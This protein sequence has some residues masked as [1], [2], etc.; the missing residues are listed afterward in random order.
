MFTNRPNNSRNQTFQE[1]AFAIGSSLSARW[2]RGH[3]GWRCLPPKK[4]PGSRRVWRS[5]TGRTSGT[6]SRSSSRHLT[7]SGRLRSRRL[8]HQLRRQNPRFPKLLCA[9]QL[10]HLP[11]GPR[12]VLPSPSPSPPRRLAPVRAAAGHPQWT[13]PLGRAGSSPSLVSCASRAAPSSSSRRSR[14]GRPPTRSAA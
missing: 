5:P 2:R 8:Q 1:N 13:H 10:R 9:C 3:Q 4:G 6:T 12:R 7:S 14:G 11:L